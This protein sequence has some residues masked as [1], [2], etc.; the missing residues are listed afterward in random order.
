MLYDVEIYHESSVKTI[1][2]QIGNFEVRLLYFLI[3]ESTHVFETFIRVKTFCQL[4]DPISVFLHLSLSDLRNA[5]NVS[6]DL[7]TWHGFHEIGI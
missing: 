7:R 2:V 6:S 4:Q 1:F 3:A 5:E